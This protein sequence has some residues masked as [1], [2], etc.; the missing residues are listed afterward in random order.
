MDGLRE[1]RTQSSKTE[2]KKYYMILLI[3]GIFKIILRNEYVYKTV[4]D[5][6]TQKTNLWLPQG[7]EKG[8]RDKLGE[9]Y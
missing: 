4:V 5:T 1:Y 9:W 7:K 2:I 3:C 8:R 6:Q